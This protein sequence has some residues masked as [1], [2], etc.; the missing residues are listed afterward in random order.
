[1]NFIELMI[2]IAV[3]GLLGLVVGAVITID[4][5]LWDFFEACHIERSGE[6]GWCFDKF[7]GDE[8]FFAEYTDCVGQVDDLKYCMNLILDNG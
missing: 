1:M 5:T 6:M 3:I 8:K 2:L 7:V 4:K